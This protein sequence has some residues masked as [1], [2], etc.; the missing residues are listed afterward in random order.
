MLLTL[1]YQMCLKETRKTLLKITWFR[2]YKSKIMRFFSSK[3]KVAV[4]LFEDYG[5][6]LKEK[7]KREIDFEIILKIKFLW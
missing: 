7:K 2:D 4:G 6:I 1:D 5:I 3:K